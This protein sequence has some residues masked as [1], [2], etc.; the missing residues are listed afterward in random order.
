MPH[1]ESS[2]RAVWQRHISWHE[3]ASRCSNYVFFSIIRDHWEAC[4]IHGFYL[5]LLP[6]P[7]SELAPLLRWL[8]Q[9][10]V[11]TV[12]W[13]PSPFAKQELQFLLLFSSSPSTWLSQWLNLFLW[14]A[15]GEV[16][17]LTAHAF[18]G[19]IHFQMKQ[20]RWPK[21]ATRTPTAPWKHAS[22]PHPDDTEV[23][24]CFLFSLRRQKCILMTVKLD[25][26][27]LTKINCTEQKWNTKMKL[28]YIWYLFFMV[29]MKD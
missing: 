3:G 29:F 26:G 17:I 23:F 15:G 6:W 20:Q 24:L 5:Y 22:I 4:T 21:I 2:I 14:H 16:T 11:S 28:K 18:A 19:W 10:K 27:F 9:L 12:Q 13:P 8:L 25:L 1:R 7:L